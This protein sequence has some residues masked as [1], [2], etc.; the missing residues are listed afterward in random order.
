[1]TTSVRNQGISIV[2]C[3]MSMDVKFDSS[4]D[5]CSYSCVIKVLLQIAQ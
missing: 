4:S 5:K 2:S 1:M 3:C